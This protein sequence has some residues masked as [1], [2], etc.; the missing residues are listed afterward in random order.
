MKVTAIIPDELVSEVKALAGEKT[1]TAALIRALEEWAQLQRV[2]A[3]NQKVKAKPFRF[4]EGF[5]ATSVRNL[6]RR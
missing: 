1:I 6:N 5:E 4:Q 2:K 3:A